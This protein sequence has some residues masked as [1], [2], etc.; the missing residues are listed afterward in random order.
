MLEIAGL[1]SW[2]IDLWLPTD[3]SRFVILF[4]FLSHHR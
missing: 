1:S 3:Y 4:L 2:S